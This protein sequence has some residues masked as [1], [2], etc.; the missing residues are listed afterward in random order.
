[1]EIGDS[2]IL[3]KG[4]ID[5]VEEDFCIT[6]FKTASN[7]WSDQ[8]ARSSLQMLIYKFLFDRT[9][10]SVN[11]TLKFEILYARN[12]ENIR[13]QSLRFTLLRPTRS[14]ACWTWSCMWP[15]TSARASF[16]KKKVS[17]A[18]SANSANAASPEGTA[19]A[20]LAFNR[21]LKCRT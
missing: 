2:G 14:S 1:M 9:Y 11:S 16:T 8:K 6:D 12:A 17:C 15:R 21:W 4:I 18:V 19:G 10:G 3:L 13:H 5:L 20:A 7:K